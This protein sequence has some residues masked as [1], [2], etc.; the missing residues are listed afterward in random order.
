MT[1]G[2]AAAG[3]AG[4]QLGGG[5]G[6]EAG[7]RQASVDVGLGRERHLDTLAAEFC[8][9]LEPLGQHRAV[10]PEALLVPSAVRKRVVAEFRNASFRILAR[11]ASMNL[12]STA[13]PL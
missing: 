13:S 8:T 3:S 7:V 12:F 2:H 5:G 10:P 9:P 1:N 4:G 11:S 6:G